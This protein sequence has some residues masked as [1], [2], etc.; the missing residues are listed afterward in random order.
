MTLMCRLWCIGCDKRMM[1]N[2][3]WVGLLVALVAYLLNTVML[4]TTFTSRGK[5]V[6]WDFHPVFVA[7]QYVLRGANPY[8]DEVTRAIHLLDY[9][10]PARP[11]EDP[12][13]FAYP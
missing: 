1:K 8:S 7:G 5:F 10:R 3:T 12:Q 4:Y 2:S 9:G 11:D 13:S 6:I